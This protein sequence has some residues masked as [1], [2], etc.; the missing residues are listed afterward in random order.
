ARNGLAHLCELFALD[1]VH[2]AS[3]VAVRRVPERID[4]EHL[5]VDTILVH[6]RNARSRDREAKIP[7]ELS[8]CWSLQWR[9]F[10]ELEHGRYCTVRMHIHGL[11][12]ATANGDLAAPWATGRLPKSM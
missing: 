12:P 1:V 6:I 2:A 3:E 7:L 8:P 5:H 10:D 9:A 11:D 4:A